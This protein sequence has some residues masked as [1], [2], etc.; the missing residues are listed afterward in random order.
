[1][2]LYSFT[3]CLFFVSVHLYARKASW[4]PKTLDLT[5]EMAEYGRQM[6]QQQT[7]REAW[8]KV[9]VGPSLFFSVLVCVI[10]RESECTVF[11]SDCLRNSAS[12]TWSGVAA[13][14][15]LSPHQP[16]TMTKA[17]E[18]SPLL[19]SGLATCMSCQPK[20]Q[21]VCVWVLGGQLNSPGSLSHMI[22]PSS[23]TC[24]TPTPSTLVFCPQILE[25]K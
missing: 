17:T 8:W 6:S 12:D 1:M 15:C 22:S 4:L 18:L 21:Q 24:W 10:V 5:S 9:C 3:H 7:H 2:L 20:Q 23:V 25:F 16:V 13:G 11:G 14:A 19:V